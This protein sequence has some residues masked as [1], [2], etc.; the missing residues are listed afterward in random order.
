MDVLIFHSEGEAEKGAQALG[1]E[2]GG[3]AEQ[4]GLFVNVTLRE[5]KGADAASLERCEGEARP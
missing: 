5:G 2:A 3:E 1:Q 4:S